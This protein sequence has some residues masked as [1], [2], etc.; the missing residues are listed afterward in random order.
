M[1][2]AV[3]LC[4]AAILSTVFCSGLQAQG[5]AARSPG[6]GVHGFSAPGSIQEPQTPRLAVCAPNLLDMR[7]LV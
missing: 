3:L 7:G 4:F 5:I 1:R 6:F 2:A